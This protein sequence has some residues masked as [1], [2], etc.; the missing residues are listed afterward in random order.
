[1]PARA[2]SAARRPRAHACLTRGSVS[3]CYRVLPFAR[4]GL[5]A[6]VAARPPSKWGASSSAAVG[7]TGLNGA[8]VEVPIL[9]CVRETNIILTAGLVIALPRL[10]PWLDRPSSGRLRRE[11][12]PGSVPLRGRSLRNATR[13]SPPAGGS[14]CL[15]H[16]LLCLASGI[17]RLTDPALVTLSSLTH[18]R[19]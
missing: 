8:E 17:H 11:A 7:C 15:S 5:R 14:S 6:A 1:M 10:E 18:A 3:F 9:F 19:L 2:G 4:W 16:A 12:P 13:P